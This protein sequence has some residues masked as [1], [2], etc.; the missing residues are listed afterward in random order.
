MRFTT[1]DPDNDSYKYLDAYRTCAVKYTEIL[2][3]NTLVGWIPSDHTQTAEWYASMWHFQQQT[4]CFISLK[5]AERGDHLAA[6]FSI[7]L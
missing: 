1:D 6:L 4:N 2:D 7:C 3:L 5:R